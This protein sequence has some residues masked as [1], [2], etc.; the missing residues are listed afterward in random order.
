MKVFGAP[1]TVDYLLSEDPLAQRA[2]ASFVF[3]LVP[4]LNPDGVVNGSHRCSLAGQDMNRQWLRPSPTLHPAVY[5]TK[6]LLLYLR[7]VGKR[8]LV[9]APVFG[10]LR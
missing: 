1:G 4:M 7:S 5:H 2:R 9:A 10:F 3:K 6:M 8:P